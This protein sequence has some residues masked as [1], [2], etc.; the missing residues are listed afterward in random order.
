[1]D[2]IQKK[3]KPKKKAYK[4]GDPSW[5]TRTYSGYDRNTFNIEWLKYYNPMEGRDQIMFIYSDKRTKKIVKH[6]ILA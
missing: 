4:T 6:R 2:D 1:V 3:E 5:E